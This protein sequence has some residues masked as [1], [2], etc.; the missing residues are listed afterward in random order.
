MYIIYY[1]IIF[2]I[3][4]ISILNFFFILNGCYWRN[5]VKYSLF[6]Y[7]ANVWVLRGYEKTIIEIRLVI[8]WL[9]YSFFS[10][11][12][13]NKSLF[14][15]KYFF[16]KYTFYIFIYNLYFGKYTLK[17]LIF[18]ITYLTKCFTENLEILLI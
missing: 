9:C 16:H 14:F 13:T 15:F 11:S 4:K 18:N 12:S 7:F 1:N 3:E 6:N 2:N 8:L 5:F 17:Y 10:F